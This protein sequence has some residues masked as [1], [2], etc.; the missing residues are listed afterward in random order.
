MEKNKE[1]NIIITKDERGN[2]AKIIDKWYKEQLKEFAEFIR[3][4]DVKKKG[5]DNGGK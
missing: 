2:E 5:E 4:N 1:E 3:N